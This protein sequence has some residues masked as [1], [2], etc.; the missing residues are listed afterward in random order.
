MT[1]LNITGFCHILNIQTHFKYNDIYEYILDNSFNYFV[2][3]LC[4][5]LSMSITI[6]FYSLFLMILHIQCIFIHILYSILLF[7]CNLTMIL[8]KTSHYILLVILVIPTEKTAFLIVIRTFCVIFL[9]LLFLYVYFNLY[10]FIIIYC[11][12][13]IILSSFLYY[14][15]YSIY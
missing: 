12:Y 9:L 6:D 7:K 3:V 5:P 10:S 13:W 8:V 2:D 14:Y 1:K 11:F 15:Y 4:F